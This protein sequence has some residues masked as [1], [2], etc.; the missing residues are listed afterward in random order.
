[1]RRFLY[2]CLA[3]SL[4]LMAPILMGYTQYSVGDGI[5]WL[6]HYVSVEGILSDPDLT[7]TVLV[8]GDTIAVGD[9]LNVDLGD[10]SG[11]W[12]LYYTADAL[13]FSDSTHVYF[14][15]S[16]DSGWGSGST[17]YFDR[18]PA[19]C[20]TVNHWSLNSDL[21]V[22][23]TLIPIQNTYGSFLVGPFGVMTIKNYSLTTDI[24]SLYMELKKRK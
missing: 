16:A 1:M 17:V 22:Y 9:S 21:D 2:V 14:G 13:A 11:Y 20:D 7:V 5:S 8:D 4:V 12:E 24:D 10:I 18:D 3:V 6:V 15:S 23:G 19:T